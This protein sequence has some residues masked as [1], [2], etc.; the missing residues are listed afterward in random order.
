MRWQG[1]GAGW[2]RELCLKLS[3]LSPFEGERSGRPLKWIGPH[4]SEH[5]LNLFVYLCFHSG[6]DEVRILL[7]APCCGRPANVYV[8]AGLVGRMESCCTGA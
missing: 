1:P 6:K 3:L 4:E 5:A 2:T 7:P 8:Q